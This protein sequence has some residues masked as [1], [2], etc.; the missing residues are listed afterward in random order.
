MVTIHLDDLEDNVL[1]CLEKIP[2]GESAIVVDE[3]EL[4]VAQLTPLPERPL[5]SSRPFGLAKGE[6]VVPDDFDA[7]LP[8]DVVRQFYGQ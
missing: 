6:F 1:A 3:D 2:A 7:P 8:D 5:S 4:P